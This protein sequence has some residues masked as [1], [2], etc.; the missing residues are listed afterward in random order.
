[1]NRFQTQTDLVL[2]Q[3][4]LVEEYELDFTGYFSPDETERMVS[5]VENQLNR[6]EEILQSIDQVDF[7]VT[8]VQQPTFD[9]S[10]L[11]AQGG[12]HRNIARAF[13]FRS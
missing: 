7:K 4:S 1:L 6:V 10:G 2:E 3:A 9:S 8:L 12:M 5:T 11:L 13:S